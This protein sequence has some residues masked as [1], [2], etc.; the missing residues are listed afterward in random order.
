MTTVVMGKLYPIKLNHIMFT[1]GASYIIINLLPSRS[2]TGSQ[3]GKA[4]NTMCI[5]AG[6]TVQLSFIR[7]TE[8]H[9]K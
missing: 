7:H 2:L 6:G 3:S 1:T 9:Y 5:G 8:N 4:S